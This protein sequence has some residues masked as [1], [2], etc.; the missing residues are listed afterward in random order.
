[1]V[2]EISENGEKDQ[3][4]I[5]S[6]GD[7]LVAR[8][9]VFSG[10]EAARVVDHLLSLK[11]RNVNIRVILG[12][13]PGLE[14]LSSDSK[15]EL[16]KD[17]SDEEQL[18]I[19]AKK[20]IYTCLD[21]LSKNNKSK[22]LGVLSRDFGKLGFKSIGYTP[23][24]PAY[25][26]NEVLN[27]VK[28]NEVDTLKRLISDRADIC[29][30]TVGKKNALI[31]AVEKGHVEC[32]ELLL[33]TSKYIKKK[34]VNSPPGLSGIGKLVWLTVN[35]NLK[36]TG[37]LIDRQDKYGKT[38]LMHAIE[39][40]NRLCFDLL[41]KNGANIN[42][43]DNANVTPLINASAIGEEYFVDSLIKQGANLDKKVKHSGTALAYSIARKH[44]KCFKLLVKAGAKLNIKD[45][46]GITP[47]ILASSENQA[48]YVE[49]LINAGADIYETDKDGQ[50]ALAYAKAHEQ[51]DS[52]RLI[53]AAMEDQS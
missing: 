12:L 3:S 41:I 23:K 27:A 9:N 7:N 19:S 16:E 6:L 38:A 14:F 18:K 53:E 39:N 45:E 43:S 37:P 13:I 33:R 31:I 21:K 49:A 44:L 34:Q 11:E 30:E 42:R 4:F 2:D 35:P 47:L 25:K 51:T 15:P 32:L 22:I 8:Q 5:K 52:I 40:K 48:E 29:S 10:P 46:G 24:K 20:S 26:R 28:N 1:M 50:D 17:M 36:D